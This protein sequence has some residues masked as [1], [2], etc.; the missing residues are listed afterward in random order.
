MTI[1]KL[2]CNTANDIERRKFG[3][4]FF[5]SYANANAARETILKEEVANL[6]AAYSVN[7]RTIGRE[8]T[9]PVDRVR[10]TAAYKKE[11]CPGNYTGMWYEIAKVETED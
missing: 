1:Y 3:E 10:V 4:R 8:R 5:T 11:F 2:F 9:E 7:A 6:K